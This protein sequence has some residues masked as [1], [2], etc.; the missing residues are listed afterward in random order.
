MSPQGNR[1]RIQNHLPDEEGGWGLSADRCRRWMEESVE[2]NP[3]LATLAMF[4]IGL[5]VGVAVGSLLAEP[6]SARR[7]RSAET[8]GRRI[9]ESL[10]EAMPPSIKQHLPG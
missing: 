4:G 5:G 2:Q 9:L 8:L 10:S 1:S 3:L 6:E 7:R